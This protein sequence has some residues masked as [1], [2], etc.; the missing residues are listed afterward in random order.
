MIAPNIPTVITRALIRAIFLGGNQY[1][2]NFKQIINPKDII[3]PEMN[4]ATA[5]KNIVLAKANINVPI[6][7]II[8]FVIIS[9]FMY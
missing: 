8:I 9:F 6:V 3:V 7:T 2:A 5:T 4:L 1:D